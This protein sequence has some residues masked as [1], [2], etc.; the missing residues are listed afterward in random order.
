MGGGRKGRDHKSK[1]DCTFVRQHAHIKGKFYLC[2]AL[3]EIYM[4]A[5]AVKRGYFQPVE[6]LL[7][8][9]HHVPLSTI[10]SKFVS[11]FIK[12]HP[13]INKFSPTHPG[14]LSCSLQ[15][16]GKMAVFL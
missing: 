13:F 1:I 16:L 11:Q 2:K 3:E 15:A 12:P 9:C 10:L 4:A 5:T 14:Y 7:V 6:L 8:L